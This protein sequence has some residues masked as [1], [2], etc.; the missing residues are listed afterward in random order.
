MPAALEEADALDPL[1]C[2]RYVEERF[3]PERMVGDY[4]EAYERA[5]VVASGER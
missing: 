2:R 3:A 4:L 1:E 5:R